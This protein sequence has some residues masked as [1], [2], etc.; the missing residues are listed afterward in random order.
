MIAGIVDARADIAV[1]A[2]Q[3][4]DQA[5]DDAI[6]AMQSYLDARHNLN[7]EYG[8]SRWLSTRNKRGRMGG[9]PSAGGPRAMDREQTGWVDRT[10][11]SRAIE[12]RD[13][14]AAMQID[15][16]AADALRALEAREKAL[17]A[18]RTGDRQAQQTHVPPGKI[19]V[20]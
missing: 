19:V 10:G 16:R 1:V 9:P 18:R 20:S 13:L 4:L 7:I 3:R 6:A 5:Q 15:A 17:E 11:R 2:D 12:T 14:V 8:F